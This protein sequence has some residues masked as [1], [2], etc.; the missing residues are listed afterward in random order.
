MSHVKKIAL[1]VFLVAAC[2]AFAQQGKDDPRKA[3]SKAEKKSECCQAMKAHG[4]GKMACC[5]SDSTCAKE[6]K[7][8]GGTQK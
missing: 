7:A 5:T 1:F 2:A 3:A 4:A 6:E 8:S